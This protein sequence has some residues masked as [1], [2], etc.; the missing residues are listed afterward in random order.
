MPIENAEH[1]PINALPFLKSIGNG[2]NEDIRTP[3]FGG[4]DRQV[5]AD[6]W[7]TILSSVDNLFPELI[8]LETKQKGKIG[9][10]SIRLPFI[11]RIPD[12]NSYYTNHSDV[13]VGLSEVIG[14][15]VIPGSRLRPLSARNSALQLPTNSNSG[16][17]LFR[18]R[19]QV[20]EES[21]AMAMQNEFYP[22]LLGWRG[23]ANGTNT[24]K[25]RV[26]WM[27]PYSLNI[28]EARFF[29][30]LHEILK[31]MY[32]F[33]AWITM[34]KVDRSITTLIDSSRGEI[35]SSDFSSYDQSVFHQQDWFFDI[36]RMAYQTSYHDEI[37]ML[38]HWFKNI[39]LVFS[40]T[41]MFTGEHGVPSGSTFT[42]QCDSIVNYLAQSSS[43]VATD[44]IQVQGDD[45][46]IVVDN[47]DTHLSH[48]TN[49]GFDVN[50]DKQLISSTMVSYLQR[51]H[52]RDYR[53]GGVCRGVYPTMRA[54]NSLLGQERF[55]QGWSSEMV[56]LRVLAILENTKWHPAFKE[57]VKF[58]VEH[59]DLQ[60]KENVMSITK[61]NT[62][63]S[64]ARTI[65][66][67]VPT[68][69]QESD[70]SGLSSFESVRLI[71]EL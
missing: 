57:F 20:Q 34:D 49:L 50:I 28:A 42:N 48:L 19:N 71:K 33:S 6:Q 11:D 66:G 18:K 35:L 64:K 40:E 14:Q 60:L 15:F 30:P 2:Y 44:L 47:V 43:P 41:Q 65:P 16:L 37:S 7:W 69:N 36:L 12:I 1:I 32:P 31:N 61:D 5:V 29:R 70:L 67:L 62:V 4:V 54:L 3:L 55:Y 22:A 46:V 8:D 23:Q 63:I 10:L 25:Q 26:V 52:H 45:A 53:I 39:P 38:Q 21:I 59:G 56:S 58:T 27:F 9:P 17:P 51:L 13:E 24:P 68:Y